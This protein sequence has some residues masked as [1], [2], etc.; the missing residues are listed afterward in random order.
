MPE[1]KCQTFT[2]HVG[3]AIRVECAQHP[4]WV[5]DID[6]QP[7]GVKPTAREIATATAWAHEQGDDT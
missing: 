1:P 2:H 4:R 7:S 5:R 3:G 6:P